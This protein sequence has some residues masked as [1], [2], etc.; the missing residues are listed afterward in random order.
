LVVGALSA[1][2]LSA[3]T[4]VLVLAAPQRSIPRGLT[5]LSTAPMLDSAISSVAVGP[6]GDRVAVVWVE[7]AAGIGRPDGSV[8]LRW[9]SESTGIGW[10]D[11]VPVFSGTEQACAVW[12]APVAVTGTTAHVAYVVRTPCTDQTRTVISYTTCHLTGGGG[13]EAA[14]TIT[15]TPFSV[16]PAYLAQLYG[17]DIAL[18]GDGNPHFVYGRMLIGTG[19]STGTIYYRGGISQPDERVPDSGD[20]SNPAIAWSNGDAHVVWEEEREG[21]AG[22]EIM[23]NRRDVTGTWDHPS[24]PPT[25]Y[26]GTATKHPR[27]PDVAAYRDHVMVTWDWQWTD[28]A[29]QYAL[30]Y[31]R[32]LTDEQKWMYVYEVGTQGGSVDPLIYEDLRD[33]LYYTYTSSAADPW[34]WGYKEYLQPSVA[35]DGKGMPTVLWHADNG[36]YDIMYSRAQSVTEGVDPFYSWSEPA[37]LHRGSAGDSASPAVALATVVSPAL[38]VAYSQYGVFGPGWDWETYYEGRE[39]GY[40]PG[41]YAYSAFLPLVLRRLMDEGDR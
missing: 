2:V 23:Y 36:T 12:S 22:F 28:E 34:H 5:N 13:C 16:P 37:V 35:L 3:L 10:R 6:D 7:E 8:W 18:D 41:D 24:T 9:A 27:N 39:A 30:A 26:K 25:S 20:S 1:G 33:S 21:G 29:D 4:V 17:V 15:S 14:R 38:H 31:T 32:Y 40:T 19:A 11:P